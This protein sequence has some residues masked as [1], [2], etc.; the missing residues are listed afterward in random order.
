[1]LVIAGEIEIDPA[2]RETAVAAVA[3]LGLRSMTVR[4]Y[5]VSSVGPLR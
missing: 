2:K 1:M 4:R 3:G 5:Q